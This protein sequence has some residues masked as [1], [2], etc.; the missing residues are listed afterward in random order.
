MKNRVLLL[1]FGLGSVYILWYLLY[2]VVNN[3]SVPSPWLVLENTITIFPILWNHL[4]ASFI[5]IILSLLI[6]SIIG[7]LIGIWMA[8]NHRVDKLLSPIIYVMMPIPKVAF[9]PIL[10]ILFG[11]GE[12]PK[13]LVMVSVMIF[14]FIIAIKD[15]LK[16][17]PLD[18]RRSATSL[19]LSP[20]DLL[21][22]IYIPAV[23]PKWFT[24]LKISF[25]ISIAVLFFSETVVSVTGLGYFIMNRWGLVNY[26]DMYS[27]IMV[28]S[29]FGLFIYECI[30]L[31]QIKLCPW[32][33]TK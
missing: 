4:L 6:S 3:V 16:E 32:L 5:R 13:I 25:S 11:L 27:G 19:S 26:L 2:L 29:I 20:K 8:Q 9:L 30:D 31:A 12:T 7:S 22:K 10:M 18:I 17:V 21:W 33:Y 1:S 28:L 23:L 15:G 14:Q 24:A